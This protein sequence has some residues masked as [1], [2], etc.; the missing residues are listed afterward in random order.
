MRIDGLDASGLTPGLGASPTDADYS[1]AIEATDWGS[2]HRALPP[3]ATWS[4]R[5][6]PRPRNS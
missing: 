5:C 1:A 2:A 6:R 4:A 3:E